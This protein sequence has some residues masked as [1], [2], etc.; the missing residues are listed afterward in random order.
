MYACMYVC[1]YVYTQDQC[2]YGRNGI[3]C[4]LNL[5]I[6]L[7]PLCCVMRV[8]VR[9]CLSPIES[10]GTVLHT[11]FLLYKWPMQIKTAIGKAFANWS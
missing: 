8:A 5:V 7:L 3:F 9:I 2:L 6:V 10:S 4:A 11:L 1:T